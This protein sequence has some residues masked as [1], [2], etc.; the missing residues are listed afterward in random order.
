MLL[1]ETNSQFIENKARNYFVDGSVLTESSFFRL[2][3]EAKKE[4]LMECVLTE[5]FNARSVM[6]DFLKSKMVGVGKD[7]SK[8]HTDLT[9]S[10]KRSAG[11]ITKVKH[12]DDVVSLINYSLNQRNIPIPR[13]ET[14]SNAAYVSYASAISNLLSKMKQNAPAFKQAIQRESKLPEE[15]RL[16]T[17]LYFGLATTAIM[18]AS[19]CYSSGIQASID[20]SYTPP[21]VQ[22]FYF[23]LNPR[24]VAIY[25]NMADQLNA[26]LARLPDFMNR[27]L[28]EQVMEGVDR[29]VELNENVLDVVFGLISRSTFLT[30]IV[31]VPVYLVRFLIY[32]FKYGVAYISKL[33]DSIS[34]SINILKKKDLDVQEFNAYKD[35]HSARNI[36]LN[37][38]FQRADSALDIESAKDKQSLR[39]AEA[40]NTS[41]FV[42]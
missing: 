36:A 12:Y 15:K 31:L 5:A 37:Q 27:G 30:D 20:S 19:E 33:S 25:Q 18:L 7:L 24:D 38:A 40:A 32:V 9:I 1:Y 8:A 13:D 35:T 26:V 4:N 22:S 10:V 23:T 17:S 29:I 11:D 16:S 41:G 3:A 14:N 28:S 2:D 42:L 39:K 6:D 21:K 34:E